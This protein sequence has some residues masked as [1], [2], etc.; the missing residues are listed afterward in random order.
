MDREPAAERPFF[1]YG[2][3]VD[4]DLLAR[5]SGETIAARQVEAAWVRGYRRTGVIGRSY[6]ILRR[7]SGGLVEGILVRGLSA[8]VR[9][10]L[11]EYEGVNYRRVRSAVRDRQ[12]RGHAAVMYAFVGFESGLRSDQRPWRLAVW[13]RRWKR[14]ALRRV[15]RLRAPLRIHRGSHRER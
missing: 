9:A 14:R 10:R 2:T 12:G 13:Q 3:L 7:R 11:D 6:P 1:F 5:V 4:L 15:G 8:S